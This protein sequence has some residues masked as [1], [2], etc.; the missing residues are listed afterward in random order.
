MLGDKGSMPHYLTDRGVELAKKYQR[1]LD[2]GNPYQ[3]KSR[4]RDVEISLVRGDNFDFVVDV[5][6]VRGV[7]L[8]DLICGLDQVSGMPGSLAEPVRGLGHLRRHAYAVRAFAYKSNL[9]TGAVSKV[10]AD[11]ERLFLYAH[12]IGVLPVH[13]IDVN[14][15]RRTEANI[16]VKDLTAAVGVMNDVS[17]MILGEVIES[18]RVDCDSE[19]SAHWKKRNRIGLEDET[20]FMFRRFARSSTEDCAKSVRDLGLLRKK[21]KFGQVTSLY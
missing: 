10:G 8:H 12:N 6:R 19:V 5:G 18:Y 2:F 21:L 9:I 11:E 3:F 15:G 20:L 16:G 14:K 7:S 1:N 17:Q 4:G 13:K